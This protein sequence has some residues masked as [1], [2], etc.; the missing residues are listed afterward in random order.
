MHEYEID[1]KVYEVANI[2]ECPFHLPAHVYNGSF[3]KM[4]PHSFVV[5]WAEE[6]FEAFRNW[7]NQNEGT[8][9][10]LGSTRRPVQS[11]L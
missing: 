5:K 6:T 8:I 1:I 4:G 3:F 2:Y 9:K 10:L 11:G 7:C